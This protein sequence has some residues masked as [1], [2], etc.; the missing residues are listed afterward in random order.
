MENSNKKTLHLN[1][2]KQ[3]FDMID[4]GDKKEEYRA[5]TPYWAKRLTKLHNFEY[6]EGMEKSLIRDNKVIF[7]HDKYDTVTFSHGYSKDRKQI[8]L[9]LKEIH[10]GSGSSYWG[11]VDGEKYFIISLGK[12]ISRNF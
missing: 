10:I 4:S 6:I 1:L 8:V 2:K 7:V 3:W 5:L 9:K 12:I 11:A